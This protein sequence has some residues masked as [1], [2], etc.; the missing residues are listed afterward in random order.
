MS[1]LKLQSAQKLKRYK[2][3]TVASRMLI[4]FYNLHQLKLLK[5]RLKAG[6]TEFTFHLNVDSV[7]WVLKRVY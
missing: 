7:S 4:T 2:H 3:S 6:L 1:L 5:T